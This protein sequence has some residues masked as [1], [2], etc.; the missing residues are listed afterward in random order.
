MGEME[1]SPQSA[2]LRF[3]GLGKYEDAPEKALACRYQ[4]AKNSYDSGEYA[5]APGERGIAIFTQ[6]E[7]NAM[8]SL[9]HISGMQIAVHSI[10]DGMLDML[11]KAYRFAAGTLFAVKHAQLQCKDMDFRQNDLCLH[12]FLRRKRLNTPVKHSIHPRKHIRCTKRYAKKRCNPAKRHDAPC[13]A[14]FL[15]PPSV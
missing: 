4:L 2:L 11:L 5:D 6:D 3:E 7:L 10:G 1:S 12:A 14:K 13:A 9:A 15:S 8:I